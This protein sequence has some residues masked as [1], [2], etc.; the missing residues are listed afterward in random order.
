MCFKVLIGIKKNGLA[1]KNVFKKY[2]LLL[3]LTEDSRYPP[4][5]LTPG[6]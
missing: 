2:I 6:I 5:I 3:F 1:L 4:I